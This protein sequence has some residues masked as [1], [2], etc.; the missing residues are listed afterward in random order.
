MK[1]SYCQT[2]MIEV[3]LGRHCPACHATAG[4]EK[5]VNR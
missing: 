5:P 1:C 4:Q 3:V 2:N